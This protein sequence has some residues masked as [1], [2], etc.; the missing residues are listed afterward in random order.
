M[1]TIRV[2]LAVSVLFVHLGHDF[3]VGGRNAVQLFYMIS[4]YLISFVLTRNEAYADP[5]TFW[6]NRAL[7]LYPAYFIVLAFALTVRIR[8][9][10]FAQSFAELPAMAKA[11]VAVVNTTLLGQDW[12]EFIGIRDGQFFLIRD[13]NE[14]GLA[15]WN[16]LL[17]QPAWSLGVELTFYAMAPFIIRRRRLLWAL[18]GLALSARLLALLTGFGAR[19]PWTYRF[20]PFE[21]ALFI[22]GALAQQRLNGPARRL[23]EA[24]PSLP[25]DVAAFI[26]LASF[27]VCYSWL[28]SGFATNALLFAGM[29]AGLPFLFEFQNRF[30][31]DDMVGE[32]SYPLYICHVPVIY[33]LEIWSAGVGRHSYA[34]AIAAVVASL[35][36]ALLLK[37]TVIDPVES[38]RRRIA[39]GE[40]R[41]A[42]MGAASDAAT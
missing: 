4:G 6:L 27:C 9:P 23:M 40:R 18:L 32:L 22:V 28:P 39:R 13:F 30:R 1:G 26:A 33:Q 36:V 3:G 7:R 20:F 25:L 15:L 31:F 19:D 11:L 17:V 16:F 34:F 37:R 12:V 42:P 38:V 2:L 8:E 5:R 41:L 24:R 10:G 14:G 29:A 21:L 35:T